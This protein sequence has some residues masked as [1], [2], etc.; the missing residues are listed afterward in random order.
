MFARA[1]TRIPMATATQRPTI[2]PLDH[3]R[4]MSYDE[5][6]EA[7]VEP[8]WLYELGGGIVDVVEVPGPG[9]GMLVHRL[10][11]LFILHDL[12]YPGVI[13]YRASGGECRLRFPFLQ[14][15]R[16]PDQAVY[17]DPKPKGKRI[18][19]RW[20]PHVVV[21]IVSPGGDDRDY[22]QKREE[23][24]RAG[25]REYWI[26]DPRRQAMLVLRNLGESW[27][28]IPLGPG[29]VYRPEVLPGL[30]VNVSELLAPAFEDDDD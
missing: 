2:G 23:Y 22:V 4:A 16:H 3:G 20:I 26:L 5:F 9:H 8:G 10:A 19:E 15:D 11:R 30:E 27:A 12:A 1:R 28:E 14:S 17:L 6:L 21:E 25:I 7:D 18:W 24:L 29:D 13:R